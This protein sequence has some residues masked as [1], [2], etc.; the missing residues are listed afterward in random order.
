MNNKI[1]TPEKEVELLKI[2]E[3]RFEKNMA[4]HKNIDWKNVEKKLENN[5]EKLWSLS[6]MERTGGEPDVV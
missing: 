4:R 3:N 6:E 2:L 5:H 1:L